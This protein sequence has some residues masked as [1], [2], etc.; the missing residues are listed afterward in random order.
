MTPETRSAYMDALADEIR[1]KR[2][3]CPILCALQVLSAVV[4]LGFTQ[5][6][7]DEATRR[8]ELEIT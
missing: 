8:S 6:E 2:D 7:I 4:A 1:K 3:V 5:E